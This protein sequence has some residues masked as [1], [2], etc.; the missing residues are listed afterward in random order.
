MAP[1]ARAVRA[2]AAPVNRVTGSIA[3]FDPASQGQFDLD[4]PPAPF[5]DLGWVE[6]FQRTAITK[7]EALRTGPGANITVQYRTQPEARLEFDLPSWGKLQLALSGGTQQ[8]N[9]LAEMPAT[10]PEPSGGD[11]LPASPVQSGSTQ[12][13]LV[14]TSD[15]LVNFNVGDIVAVDVDYTGT[16]GYLG[17]GAPGTYLS[18]PVIV[19]STLDLVRR[20]TFN[21]SRVSA[22]TSSS[23]L[24]A[25]PL[26]AAPATGMG[27]QKV[28]AFVD[29][30]GSSFF[31]EW[32]GLFVIA[33][34]SGG[35]SCFFYP[36]LQAAASARETRQDLTAPLFSHMLHV[37]L[38]ALPTTDSNDGETVLCYR[39]YFPA[40]NAAL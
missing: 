9:V 8:M 10:L 7:Y 13:E 5:I 1:A 19:G 40:P 2:Y 28:V 11:P 38:H 16:T 12:T 30:E 36:R 3:A 6:N 18:S 14:L 34:D 32:S 25:E 33:P 17:S 4:S 37:S 26:L 21:V 29:R 27:V 23:L 15:Q 35:R 24:L 22:K 31:Q 39:S 20:I